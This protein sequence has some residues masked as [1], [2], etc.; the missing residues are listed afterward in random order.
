MRVAFV[1]NAFPV[2]S[3]TFVLRQ[4][5]GAIDQG[6]EVDIYACD[7]GDDAI[8]AA[9]S[10]FSHYRLAERVRYLDVP[11]SA[12]RRLAAAA[13]I[14]RR[15][16]RTP[17][18]Y[19]RALNPARYGRMAL[20]QRLLIS[21]HKLVRHGRRMYDIIHCQFGPLGV[22]ASRLRDIGAWDGAVITAFRGYDATKLL[23]ESPRRYADLFRDG[24]FFLPVSQALRD[25]LSAHGCDPAKMQVH[26]SGID[27]DS[28]EYRPR[29]LVPGERV[30]LMSIARLVEKK[31]IDFAVRAAAGLVTRGYNVEYEVI[32]DGPERGALMRLIEQLDMGMRIRLAGPRPHSETL[33]ALNRAHLLIAPSVTAADGDQEGIPNV[34]KEAM[35]LGLPV[36]ATRHGGNAELVEHGVSGYLVPERDVTA[37]A[38]GIAELI[39]ASDRWPS[40]GRAG[41]RKVET[42]FDARRLAVELSDIY[43]RVAQRRAGQG[44]AGT[45]AVESCA[46]S[47][48]R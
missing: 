32:G 12:P 45:A 26:H 24:E 38:N 18:L 9:A 37:L 14:L 25:I 19:T 47:E 48:G 2:V 46:T 4:I 30:R 6:H 5:V 8:G 35:A 22:I 21:A 11:A 34:V 1:V 7:R 15:G 44:R 29:T 17:T 43:L 20:S 36:I 42:E 3:E 39:D 31:G 16:W 13:D 27:C 23:K 10:V 40:F 28:L 33:A 41:R